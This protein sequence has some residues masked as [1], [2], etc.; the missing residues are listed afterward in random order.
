MHIYLQCSLDTA[1]C[2]RKFWRSPFCQAFPWE[3]GELWIVGRS[4]VS[5]ERSS[6]PR[7]LGN[8]H[9]SVSVLRISVATPAH[10]GW[11]LA[12][13]IPGEQFEDRGAFRA[14]RTTVLGV[15]KAGEPW[16]RPTACPWSTRSC[17][18]VPTS[19]SEQQRATTSAWWWCGWTCCQ[20][21]SY[22]CCRRP[23]SL[24]SATQSY[25][26]NPG[27][28]PGKR[29]PDEPPQPGLPR[30][31]SAYPLT[32]TLRHSGVLG[33]HVTPPPRTLIRLDLAHLVCGV[34]IWLSLIQ[35]DQLA[36]PMSVSVW[37]HQALCDLVS[38]A[39][40]HQI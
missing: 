25:A 20:T 16:L 36:Q 19:S 4:G 24:P 12:V 15:G 38:L 37:P 11:R 2:W 29:R 27:S 40:Y 31:H 22:H 3:C 5:Q 23:V 28:G 8:K 7:H 1:K 34:S 39:L 10:S 13:P 26:T 35:A 32:P 21:R 6:E 14:W 9:R 17:Q 30:S 33:A 18:M